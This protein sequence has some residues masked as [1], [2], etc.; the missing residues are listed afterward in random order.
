MC[1]YLSREHPELVNQKDKYDKHCLHHI[2]QSG[3][4]EC[5]GSIAPLFLK[6]KSKA[7]REQFIT[8]LLDRFGGTIL[9][10]ACATGQTDMCLY[11]TREYPKLIFQKTK[12][13]LHCLHAIAE[14]GSV[15]CFQ[16]IS[17]LVL[18]DKPKQERKEYLG[19]LLDENGS[20][21]L[22]HACLAGKTDMCFYLI[23]EIPNVLF[24]KNNNNCHCLHSIAHNGS[25]E[26][27]QS[28][29][30]LVLKDK[31]KLAKERF[32]QTLKDENGLTVLH[33]ACL[34]NQT[35]MCLYLSREHPELVNQKDKYDNHCLHHIAQSGNVEC[36]RSI[37]PL[38]L[39]DK[40]KAEHEQFI[41]ALL[42][43]DGGTI[44]HQSCAAGQTNMCL[45]LIR[46]FPKLIFQNT[47]HNFHCLHVIA[48]C[49]SVECFQSISALVL[50][51]KTKVEKERFI[52]T[53]KDENGL[54]VLHH[55][56]LKN[57]TDMCL[58][59]SREHPELV[60]QKDKYDKHC[61]HHIAQSGNV[62]CFRSI[63][64]LFLKEKSKAEREQFITTLLDRFGGTILHQACAT[65]QTDMCL[66]LTR[67]YPKLIFQ[68]TKNNL[69]CLHAIAEGGSVE[70]FQSISALVL[71]DKPKQERKE[72]LGTLLDENGSTVLHHACLA[73]KTDM[74]FYL[75]KE[76]PNVLFQKNY[77]NCHCLHSIAHNGSVECFQSISA[78]VLKDKTKVEIK[79]FMETLKDDS[80]S[81]V[82]HHACLNSRTDMCLYLSREYPEL[83]NQK[84]KY[85]KH[86]LHHI[87]QSGNV[88]CFR[89][90]AQLV[91]KDKSKSESEQ[92]ITT[93]LDRFGR[94][95]LHQACATGQTD[96]CLYL[97]R[98]YP[99]LIFQKTK[100]NLHCLHTIAQ[101][102]SVECFQSISAIVLKDK[103]KVEME[104]FMETLKDENGLTVLHHACLNNQTDM[105]LYLSREHP[106]L[107]NQKDKYDKHCL[108]HIAQSGNVECFRT[109]A[110]LVL[111]DKSK[112]ESEQFITTLL[113]RFGRT[114]LHQACATGQTDV[115]L[116]LIRE[117]PK[118]IFQKTKNNLHCLHTIAQ[119]GSVECFQ[120]ISAIVLKDKTKVEMEH[121]METLKDENGLTVLHHACLNNQTD[122]CLYLS[123]EHPELF[124]QKDKN[125]NHCLHHIAQSGNVECFRSI[126]PLFLK[127]KSKAEREQFI[128]A[129]L[130]KDGGTILHQSC[131]TGQTNMCLYLI[132]EFPN[133]IFQNT[134]HNFH[135]LH[136]IAQC[137]SVECFQSISALVLKD[138]T[139]VEKERF[140]QTLKD[141]NGLTVLHHACLNNQTD[142]CLYL[143]REYPELVNQKDKYDKHCLHHIAQSGNVE[144][145]R[146]IAPLFLKDKS[147]GEREQF[148][149]TLLD[150]GGRT[151]LHQSC[152]TGQTN[153]CLYLI[154]EF[155]KLIFQ[156]TKHNFHCLHVIAQ[157]GRVEC[158]QSISA[159]VLKDKTKLEKERFIQTL[160]DENGL[161]V[162]HHACLY[163]RTDMCLYLSREH[164]ELVNQKDKYDNHCLHHIT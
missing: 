102:G 124:I 130:N 25:V 127:D 33:H 120:S 85:D 132:R 80:G 126:A 40:S 129:L 9:H 4:V 106:E 46:E 123:R 30:A 110:Q 23:K 59:L 64:P 8:T 19:T 54:T 141:E 34:Y 122:M 26:C 103:T 48:Q 94:T 101:C 36:F 133:L 52:Q 145:F 41:T 78:L 147:K 2:A 150:I 5:F 62:E 107:V 7:E 135:C 51:D 47:K 76:I 146:S 89:T 79:R 29:S 82:L 111:K 98:E 71:K 32:I 154:R 112:S 137:G 57:Q 91:L 56:C 63:A 99:K 144:C 31:T 114:I 43:T 6:E 131:A 84:N 77:N 116:Y 87:A 17:A 125:D 143:S 21:V 134:K 74:C 97:I 58:Y 160:K 86:C 65:G 109:I 113:D 138:K 39:K 100:N 14:G 27:F 61:L 128:T 3:N 157:C 55:A 148:I 28:I 38:F 119:C 92:F 10:Q 117:Y 49:G 162:L 96:V 159:L 1:L 118:L 161:T 13:N 152:A 104:H 158:F 16:S 53:L 139:K 88:E 164:P 68:K 121:F 11:L 163:N 93:L 50:K 20:T 35:D 156:N 83:V 69:H 24:Q 70:C 115:C 18:K 45:Y 81:T 44:L 12:Y 149:T 153:M 66:Y 140:I 42:N 90:I 67:E 75:I 60:N 136:V 95:I 37:A 155:P 108:H 105:C 73:G 15:E 142:M 151:I 22:H 72:Y